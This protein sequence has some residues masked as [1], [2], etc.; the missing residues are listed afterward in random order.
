MTHRF[1]RASPEV[2]EQCRRDID[3]AFGYPSDFA[4]TCFSPAAEGVMFDGLMYLGIRQ[5]FCEHPFAGSLL[6]AALASGAVEE[7]DAATYV[8]AANPP[9]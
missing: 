9:L 2:Y 1:F 4:Q 3:A 8:A 7:I 6:A 5:E